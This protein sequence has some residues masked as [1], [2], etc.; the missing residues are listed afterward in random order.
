MTENLKYVGFE[1]PTAVVMNKFGLQ[2]YN[3]VLGQEHV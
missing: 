3:D 1:D 2:E